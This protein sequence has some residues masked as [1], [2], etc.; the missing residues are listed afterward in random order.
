MRL[1]R[2]G[3]TDGTRLIARET[4]AVETLA[5]IAISRRVIPLVN[6]SATV[7]AYSLKNRTPLLVLVLKLKLR[8]RLKTGGTVECH[9]ECICVLGW[10]L[11]SEPADGDRWLTSWPGNG[12]RD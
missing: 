10:S 4:V 7:I 11:G 8:P 6:V 12:I 2:T 5:R 9:P 3:L 1:A